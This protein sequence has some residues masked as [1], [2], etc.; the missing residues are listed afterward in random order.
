[1]KALFKGTLGAQTLAL[2][3]MFITFEIFLKEG[4]NAL[5]GNIHFC[6]CNFALILTVYP[7]NDCLASVHS[8]SFP[9][10]NSLS[11]KWWVLAPDRQ[12]STLAWSAH[13][14]PKACLHA[15]SGPDLFFLFPTG[16][17]L[18]LSLK[19][20]YGQPCLITGQLIKFAE[21]LQQ[22]KTKYLNVLFSWCFVDKGLKAEQNKKV[23]FPPCIFTMIII[24]AA[25]QHLPGSTWWH[26]QL[27]N[28]EQL[29][30]N[31][32]WK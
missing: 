29:F 16:T 15:L 4:W 25:H 14:S 10:I 7:E 2:P 23:S 18:H 11:A 30:K 6:L 9:H 22:L 32:D 5:K 17:S 12:P 28:S 20:W 3:E 19:S 24:N 8:R 26:L 13:G 1:M 21:N 27:R 31:N